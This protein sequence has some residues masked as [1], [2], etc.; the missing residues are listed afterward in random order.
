MG[1]ILMQDAFFSAVIEGRADPA[2]HPSGVG[3]MGTVYSHRGNVVVNHQECALG[4]KS[5]RC[6]SC[7]S[8][9]LNAAFC[10]CRY[11]RL[12]RSFVSFRVMRLPL[13]VQNEDL[14]PTS[15]EFRARVPVRAPFLV[16]LKIASHEREEVKLLGLSAS[17]NLKG[18]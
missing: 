11:I 5:S 10:S 15:A 7:K 8:S 16:L 17:Y 3:E 14:A 2:F 4:S 13:L 12:L 1:S 9:F 18:G 6:L